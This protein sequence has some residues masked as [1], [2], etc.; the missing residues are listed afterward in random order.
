MKHLNRS[1]G[2]CSTSVELRATRSWYEFSITCTQTRRVIPTYVHV[3]M[4]KENPDQNGR[5]T[6][7]MNTVGKIHWNKHADLPVHV[8]W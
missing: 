3:Y 4:G 1:D 7:S 5:A 6:K 8:N 2:A